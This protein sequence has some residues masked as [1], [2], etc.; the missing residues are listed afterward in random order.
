[1]IRGSGVLLHISSL[2]SNY[3][4]GTFGKEAYKFVRKLKK[5]NQKYWQILPLSPTGFKDSPYQSFSAYA[6]NPYFIDLDLLVDDDMLKD[7]DIKHLNWGDNDKL[8]DY[9]LIYQNKEK[10]LWNAFKKGNRRLDSKIKLFYQKNKFWL[11]DY[12][13]YM[14]CKK[15]FNNQN[16]LNWDI[17]FK[18]RKR[19]VINELK[20]ENIE[21]FDF[22]VFVQYIAYSQYIKLK[23]FANANGIYIIGDCPIYVSLD[24][25]DV[26]ANKEQFLL[27]SQ[28]YPELVAGVPPDY[29][30][31]TGQL[32][33]NP[34]YDYNR[35]KKN[36]YS[37][38][39][40]RLKYN[41]NLYDYIRLDHFRGFEAYYAIPANE[42]TALNGKWY[43]GPDKDLFNTVIEQ[44]PSIN[45]IAEDLGIITD[46]VK[47]L[48][49]DFKLPGLK[50]LLFAFDSL[51]EN[52][53]YLP[54]NF[55]Q[56]C[57][58]YLG[59]HDNNTLYGYFNENLNGFENMKQY[60][61]VDLKENVYEALLDDMYK[62]KADCVILQI[63]DILKQDQN[64]RMNIPGSD[65][66]NWQYRLT[67][68][69][70][71]NLDLSFVEYLTIKY[72]R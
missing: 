11:E 4:I 55:E 27:N 2:P 20:N 49:D 64:Y 10:V 45:L 56:N 33:G 57:M 15:V 47:K 43:K 14:T 54:V 6:I 39:I 35:M 70:L 63:Q 12:A 52:H 40:Q 46:E 44:I 58:A 37:W 53:P 24:S 5:A 67:K 9:G 21:L 59:S 18:S 60:Y 69:Q 28:Y 3:G 42:T 48:K 1:M 72:E 51:E 17:D 22:Y 31:K 65:S 34:I 23:R 16:W 50:I 71:D 36:N 38:W 8:V 62:S 19:S 30:S 29:F 25:S 13:L 68:E 41:S 66:G 32:W 26:W 7:S 61:G